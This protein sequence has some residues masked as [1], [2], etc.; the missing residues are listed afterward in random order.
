MSVA[1]GVTAWALLSGALACSESEPDPP[2]AAIGALLPFSG[3]G[4]GS[5][6]SWERGLLLAT[7]HLNAA[8]TS[9]QAPFGLVIR[10]PG[11][12][13]E[14]LGSKVSKLRARGAVALIGPGREEEIREIHAD[15]D[16]DLPHI[17]PNSVS[18]SEFVD[19][20]F[21]LYPLAPAAEVVACTLA[22]AAY[23]EGHGRVIVAHA[24]DSYSIA[25]ALAFEYAFERM[26]FTS[27]VGQAGTVVLPDAFDQQGGAIED[28]LEFGPNAVVIVSNPLSSAEFIYNWSVAGPD[29]NWFLAPALHSDE[30]LL[31]APPML[32]DG[33]FVISPSLPQSGTATQEFEG[34]FLARWGEVPTVETYF[35]YDAGILAGLATLS[36]AAESGDR[37]PDPAQVAEHVLRVASPPGTPMDWRDLDD[38]VQ[39]IGQGDDIDFRGASGPVTLGTESLDVTAGVLRLWQIEDGN[40]VPRTFG[41]CPDGVLD[42]F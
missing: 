5:G 39:R 19:D 3:N 8:I 36:A 35:H 1:R 37:F 12:G 29:M 15:E 21:A 41:V 6:P 9:D 42:G 24:N 18:H 33:A 22:N 34:V 32:L 40:F 38:A 27:L 16:M 14:S 17:I 31:N 2:Q 25:F 20:P 26:R 23:R 10:D 28:I 4:A 13:D 30:F 7:E 11:A